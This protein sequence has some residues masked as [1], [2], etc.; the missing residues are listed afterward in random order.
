MYDQFMIVGEA[1]KNVVEDG[2]VI[3]FQLGVRLPYY[4]GI[5]LSLI[6]DTTLTVDGEVMPCD[7][8]TV[9]VDGKTF[10]LSALEDEPET[11]WEFGDVGILTVRK[12]G[13]LPSGAHTVTLHQHL[14]I[15]YVPVGF[16]GTDTKVLTIEA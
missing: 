2:R 5:V 8:M 16:S 13:G 12:P 4:R 9:T 14:K 6:G 10:Q 1:F 15:S 3:G 11:K 7:A